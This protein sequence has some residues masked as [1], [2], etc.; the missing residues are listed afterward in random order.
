MNK[1]AEKFHNLVNTLLAIL[2]SISI[3]LPAMQKL[4]TG[5]FANQPPTET[6]ENRNLAELPNWEWSIPAIAAFPQR[7]EAYYNDRFGFRTTLIRWHNWVKLRGLGVSGSEK[8]I[9]GKEGWLFY[10]HPYIIDEI[11]TKKSFTRDELQHWEQVLEQRRDWLAKQG[12]HYL[13]VI[14]PNKHTIYPEYLPDSLQRVEKESRLDQLITYLKDNSELAILDLRSPLLNAKKRDRIYH[15]TDSHWNKPGVFSAYQEI[16]K[17]L[18]VWFPEL[19]AVP[20]SAFDTEVIYRE[21]GDLANMLG[22]KDILQEEVLKFSP[23]FSPL[24]RQVEPEI[25]K[26]NLPRDRQPFASAI[27][28][29]TLPRA[30]MFH[31]SFALNLAPLLSEHFQRIIFLNQYEFD[32]KIIQQERPDVVIQEMVERTLMAP[33]PENPPEMFE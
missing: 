8:V 28:D 26:A 14:A 12:I 16:I 18:A 30:V 27:A 10:A 29:A 22:L 3:S 23:R 15:R 24:A 20:R 2:F 5:K 31:D 17:F 33:L 25:E 11:R 21:G 4:I 7:F 19:T 32:A 13:F 1:G 6:W 9:I